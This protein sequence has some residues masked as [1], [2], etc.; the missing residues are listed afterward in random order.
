MWK[1]KLE[2]ILYQVWDTFSRDDLA[3]G[4]FGSD[5]PSL[6]FPFPSLPLPVLLLLPLL[7]AGA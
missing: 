5:L 6:A 4:A 3:V 7:A 1:A 2:S